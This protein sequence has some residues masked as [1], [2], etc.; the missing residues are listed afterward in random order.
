MARLKL[1]SCAALLAA[2]LI[3]TL[4]VLPQSGSQTG[5]VDVALVIAVD[6]SFSVDAAEY[7]LQ[8]MGLGQALQ[9]PD[10]ASAIRKGPNQRIALAVFQ[11][12]DSNNQKIILPW[13]ILASEAELHAVANS[14]AS[15]PRRLA[16]GGTSI[17]N[18]LLFASN[19]LKLAPLALRRTIDISTDGRNNMGPPVPPMRDKIVASG[20]T[21]N[22]LA[23][24]NEYPTLDLYAEN[25][26]AGGPGNFVIKAINYNDYNEAMLRKLIREI[27]GPG[28]S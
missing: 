17:T 11:W 25:Q 4:P 10:I 12:S 19:Q 18:A 1:F 15:M 9:N 6:C 23:I 14:L 26:I 28:I 13:T 3:W 24:V 22:A 5:Q 7:R 20:V 27:T 21:I 2:I 8:M 16:E